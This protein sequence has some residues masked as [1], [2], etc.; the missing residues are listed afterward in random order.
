MLQDMNRG[1]YQGVSTIVVAPA[2]GDVLPSRLEDK[3]A[4]I[5]RAYRDSRSNVLSR[6]AGSAVSAS[7]AET[8]GPDSGSWTH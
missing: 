3:T 8:W 4:T 1:T 5:E 7:I 2:L 6:L